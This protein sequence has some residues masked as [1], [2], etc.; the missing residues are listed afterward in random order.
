MIL[1]FK[2]YCQK[3]TSA[4]IFLN[5]VYIHILNSYCWAFEESHSNSDEK[6]TVTS[7][8][9]VVNCLRGKYDFLMEF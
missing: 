7:F 6:A 8:V 9:E 2:V 5:S 3:G 4:H 1:K